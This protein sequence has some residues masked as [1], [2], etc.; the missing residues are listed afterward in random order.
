MKSVI[1][2]RVVCTGPGQQCVAALTSGV[3]LDRSPL[4]M[5]FTVGAEQCSPFRLSVRVNG[6]PPI[7]TPWLGWA[8]A[9]RCNALPLSVQLGL[10][11]ALAGDF[12]EVTFDAEGMPGGCNAGRI[13][14]WT[15]VLELFDD[16]EDLETPSAAPSVQPA[17][18]AA[19]WNNASVSVVLTGTDNAGGAGVREIQHKLDDTALVVAPGTQSNVS[20]PDE[21]T[22]TITF[23]AV[24]N[25][26]NHGVPQ[27][28]EV[29]IDKTAPQTTATVDSGA[30]N[31]VTLEATDAGG[32]GVREIRYR[33]N[34]RPEGIAPGN[35]VEFTPS[36][37]TSQIMYFAV[38]VADNREAAKMISLASVDD[39]PP[40]TGATIAPPPNAAGWHSG[41][42]L[43]TLAATDAG[44]SGVKEIRYKLND[45][46]ET[47]SAG[48]TAQITIANEGVTTIK[49]Y[50]VDNAGNEEPETSRTVKLDKG[51]PQVVFIG[52]AGTYTVDQNIDIQVDAQDSLSGV[53]SITGNGVNGPAY[54]FPIGKAIDVTGSAVDVADNA[55]QGNTSFTVRV[56]FASVRA[57]IRRLIV[58][59]RV[60]SA[61]LLL[62]NAAEAASVRG[63]L[64]VRRAQLRALINLI[65]AQR[66]RL[67]QVNVADAMI[68]LLESLL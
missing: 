50:A 38:D 2:V 66:G 11:A 61:V 1:P 41:D 49:F 53:A 22:T 17:P 56:T 51:A 60:R 42:V 15:G 36:A 46:A 58:N 35:L 62:L 44:G 9:L 59:P 18:N 65:R 67:I 13:A 8:G 20:V 14:L 3:F 40:A 63:N 32:S 28:F 19:G 52:N 34:D 23:F 24:D 31:R 29:K 30:N 6:G 43:V 39:L 10:G 26:G 47:I 37:G 45:G 64:E 27:C 12:N 33:E 25:A 48:D 4:F 54:T 5:R 55:A 16:V 7:L 68:S 57:L 21:G